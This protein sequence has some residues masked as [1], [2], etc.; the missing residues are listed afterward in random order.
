MTTKEK[1]IEML[2]V[3]QYRKEITDKIDHNTRE[4]LLV[5]IAFLDDPRN[6]DLREKRSL[7]KKLLTAQI[8]ERNKLSTPKIAK[9][10]NMAPHIVRYQYNK[11]VGSKF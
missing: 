9:Q 5:E 1:E 6:E 11:F 8:A 7:G 2:E 4:L 3:F 10:F